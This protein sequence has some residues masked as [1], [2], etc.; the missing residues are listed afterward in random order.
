MAEANPSRQELMAEIAGLRQRLEDL[1]RA[2]AVA[3]TGNWRMNVQTNEL[4]WSEENHRIFGIPPGA[5]MS[6]ETFLGTVHPEDREY[7]D[8][9]WMAGD[10]L[11]K[12]TGYLQFTA[13]G[14]GTPTFTHS[15]S[16]TLD[17]TSGSGGGYLWADGLAL[18]LSGPTDTLMLG[19]YYGHNQIVSQNGGSVVN[20]SG[21]TIRGCG[22]I[23]GQLV[24]QGRLVADHETLAI[25]G[26]VSGAGRVEVANGATLRIGSYSSLET[27]DFF[28]SQTASLVMEH[29]S[30]L[31][32]QRN[33]AFAQTDETLWSLGYARLE[34]KGAGGVQQ[35]LEIGGRDFGLAD[36]G[37]T[38][39]FNLPQLRLSGA[40][41][42]A[43]LVDLIDN[44]NRSSAEALYVDLLEVLPGTTLCLNNLHLYTW[45]NGELHL[46]LAREGD[47]FGGGKII[48]AAVPVPPSVVLL[49]SALAGL[50]GARRWFQKG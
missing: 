42:Y 9:K 29:Y 49:G 14:S 11:L 27:G 5:A 31:A 3:H 10:I 28:M 16:L 44:G 50:M 40:N 2:Q 13:T 35:A 23:S 15:G 30:S 7:V 25:Y 33:F 22:T 47:L 19:T 24:N 41:T 39:N 34:M 38:A 46:V 6:Y 18:T 17:A 32:L 12:D 45:L 1:N 8:Q 36:D 20:A 37:F 21:H 43:S 48:D 4:T 26:A